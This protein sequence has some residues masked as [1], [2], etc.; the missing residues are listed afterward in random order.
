M[1]R[2]IL[3][4]VLVVILPGF[5]LAQDE[6]GDRHGDREGNYHQ[7]HANNVHQQ[8]AV[9]S[10]AYRPRGAA[11]SSQFRGLGV[12]SYPRPYARTQLLVVPRERSSIAFPARGFGG[13]AI[14]ANVFARTS[15]STNPVIRTHMAL[16]TGGGFRAQIGIYNANER[17]V[18]QYYWHTGNGFNYCHYYDR[19]GYHWY[20]WYLGN[21]YFWTRWYSNNWWWY[22]PAYYRWC[23][24]HDGGW[25]W[26]DP[27]TTTVYVYNNGNYM[28][29]DGGVNANVNVNVGSG[30]GAPSAQTPVQTQGDSNTFYSNDGNREVK[31]V[32]TDAFLYDVSGQNLFK[33]VYL[34]TNVTSVKFSNTSNGKPLQVMLLFSDGSFGLFD[35]QGNSINGGNNSA[36]NNNQPPV[37]NMD[38]SIDNGG[39]NNPSSVPQS[40]S[41]SNGN[42]QPS[43][44]GNGNPPPVPGSG[45]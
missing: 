26:Q 14:H 25:W 18:G 24:W 15:F 1:K 29:A 10:N 34:G 27:D 44:V 43:A 42:A 37:N 23:Y 8:H 21:A 36:V 30:Q 5:V 20:G 7:G 4:V 35:S 32:G 33:P 12:R 41:S 28:P 13:A 3:M 6:R 9:R 39:S 16:I 38:S 45:T 22:D 2:I 31:L 19:W 11:V 40:D 17:I